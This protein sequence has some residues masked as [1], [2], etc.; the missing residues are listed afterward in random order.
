MVPSISLSKEKD[1]S[2]SEVQESRTR[3]GKKKVLAYPVYS[4]A[5]RAQGPCQSVQES[6]VSD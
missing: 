2:L 3:W 1:L 4:K 6:Q 5:G